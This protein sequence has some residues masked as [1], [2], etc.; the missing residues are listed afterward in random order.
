MRQS[1][2]SLL[3]SGRLSHRY[4]PACVSICALNVLSVFDYLDQKISK[5]APPGFMNLSD[6]RKAFAF[7]GFDC[8]SPLV[9]QEMQSI[10]GARIYLMLLR[11]TA[12]EPRRCIDTLACRQQRCCVLRCP[13]HYC[14]SSSAGG[15]WLA[16]GDRMQRRLSPRTPY[17]RR[18]SL[19]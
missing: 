13:V 10:V 19:N 3:R 11:P 16:A 4:L 6:L 17:R 12:A 15:W 1:V 5:E 18:S 8:R 14:V 9:V 2:A 7:L